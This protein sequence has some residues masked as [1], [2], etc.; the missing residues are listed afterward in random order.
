MAGAC[1]CSRGVVLSGRIDIRL[2]G[3]RSKY[4]VV[5][6]ATIDGE[7]VYC[8]SD[9]ISVFGTLHSH[10]RNDEVFLYAFDLLEMNGDGLRRQPLASR[11]DKLENLLAHSG[12]GD[13]PRRAY[14]GRRS[15]HFQACVQDG[16]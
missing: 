8:G 6:S 9:G 7:A 16:A 1:G 12:W 2:S 5:Q 14:G 11:K 4:C 13:A 3:S 10:A 15:D